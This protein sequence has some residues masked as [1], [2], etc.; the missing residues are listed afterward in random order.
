MKHALLVTTAALAL[1]LGTAGAHA[2][3][4]LTFGQTG[5]GD[6]VHATA[7]GAGTSTTITGTG[8]A[9]DITEIDAGVATPIAAS[10]TFDFT[11]VGAATLSGGIVQQSFDGSF[12]ITSGATN[13]LSGT[14][15]DAV[16]GTGASLTLDAANPPE[17][18]HFTSSVIDALS[19]PTGVALSFSDVTPAIGLDG[20]TLASFASTIS[21]DFSATAVPEPASL[22][23]LGLGLAGL[24]F[25]RRRRSA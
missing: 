1:V 19:S 20:S 4:I 17:A 10:M 5:S 7:N 18:V 21:G 14:F 23:V 2:T 9:V 3:P 22:A 15:A 6:T 24:G 16:F 12:A 13:Y 8:I 11:S 25:I